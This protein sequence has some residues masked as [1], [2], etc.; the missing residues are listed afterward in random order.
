[1]LFENHCAATPRSK[2]DKRLSK[3]SCVISSPSQTRNSPG[4]ACEKPC[5]SNCNL[6]CLDSRTSWSSASSVA[7][8]LRFDRYNSRC[9]AVISND[10]DPNNSPLSMWKDASIVAP[11]TLSAEVTTNR[12]C[13]HCLAIK[14]G[15][16]FQTG[17][18]GGCSHTLNFRRPCRVS[19]L[20]RSISR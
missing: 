18:S 8:S 19:R 4:S 17:G 9:V 11:I 3:A 10:T 15:G 2:C 20:R 13:S 1:M 12:P 5:K 6:C 16:E 14:A 7:A